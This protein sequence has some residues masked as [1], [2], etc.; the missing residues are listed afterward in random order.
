[1]GLFRRGAVVVGTQA[2]R[3]YSNMLSVRLPSTALRTQDID[4]AHGI[5]VTLPSAP[6]I[7]GPPLPS[8]TVAPT[9]ATFCAFAA[10]G[11]ASHAQDPTASSM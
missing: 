3:A 11:A 10:S 2:F 5:E 6:G 8:I 9:I 1:M 4:L 7:G